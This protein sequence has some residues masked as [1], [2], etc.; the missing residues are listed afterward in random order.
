MTPIAN[1]HDDQR[2]ASRVA[3]QDE[4]SHT[5]RFFS[6]KQ[7][8]RDKAALSVKRIGTDPSDSELQAWNSL[9]TWLVDAP[10]GTKVPKTRFHLA[11]TRNAFGLTTCFVI[12]ATIAFFHYRPLD[13]DIKHTSRVTLDFSAAT[14]LPEGTLAPWQTRLR[15]VSTATFAQIGQHIVRSQ[16]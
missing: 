1:F 8:H 5:R 3:S 2:V 15:R 12:L 16:R 9:P 13:K 11:S 4:R 14:P 10:K 6:R 7:S